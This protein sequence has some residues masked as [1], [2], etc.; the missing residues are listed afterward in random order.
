[1]NY[2]VK[3]EKKMKKSTRIVSSIL[4]VV[5]VCLAA[6][7]LIKPEP[8]K[9]QVVFTCYASSGFGQAHW[10]SS[11]RA[12]AARRAVRVCQEN[13]PYGY[14]CHLDGCDPW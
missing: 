12:H 6:V 4:F 3:G 5:V 10:S 11:N 2:K 8:A 9:A 1:M 7:G 13:T 14:W